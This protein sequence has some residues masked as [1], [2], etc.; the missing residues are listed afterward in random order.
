MIHDP[1]SWLGLF[2]VPLEERDLE[3]VAAAARPELLDVQDEWGM[4]AL[5]L[6]VTLR[7][8][9]AVAL[10]LSLGAD[11]ERRYHR[12][13]ETALHSAIREHQS[14]AI[15]ALLDA[16]A[17]PD[18]APYGGVT[19]R[20]GA[21]RL[22]LGAPFA[23]IEERDVTWPP[24]QNAEHLSEFH[25]PKFEIPP[26]RAREQLGIGQAIDLHVHGTRSKSDVKVRIFEVHGSGA[27]VR[28]RARLSPAVQETNLPDGLTDFAFG[29]EHVATIY[30]SRPR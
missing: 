28:Y 30:V 1:E 16:G 9:E 20:D 10:L 14:D 2:D 3:R 21:I 7:W 29:P 13:G 6:A 17:D 19:A 23:G 15:R 5:H 18:A 26:R 8:P 27:S 25:H 12:T 22:G 4:T 11:P 24:I